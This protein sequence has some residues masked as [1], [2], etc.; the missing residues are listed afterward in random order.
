MYLGMLGEKLWQKVDQ[1]NQLQVVMT[2]K[3]VYSFQGFLQCELAGSR[4]HL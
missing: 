3:V 1:G 4:P 2:A